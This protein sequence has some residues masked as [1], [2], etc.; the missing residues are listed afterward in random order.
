MDLL[1]T[2]NYL[3]S[4]HPR[5]VISLSGRRITLFLFTLH[6]PRHMHV[7]RGAIVMYPLLTLLLIKNVSIMKK[8]F[9]ILMVALAMTAFVACGDT[10]E[11]SDN[12]G[13]NGTEQ[14]TGNESVL[15]FTTWTYETGTQGAS[16]Y[17]YVSVAFSP[18]YDNSVHEDEVS[19]RKVYNE[20]GEPIQEYYV[21]AYSYTGTGS[22]GNGSMT[23]KDYNT[24]TSVGNVTFSISGSTMTLNFRGE[25]YSLNKE[26][27]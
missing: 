27:N 11:G 24:G 26:N 19:V 21:G 25:T 16:N 2:I 17:Q 18:F 13:G 20:D 22:N 15:K 23:V 5:K 9:S 10:N 7:H 14:P 4:T 6:P 12:N 8:L 3:I 1:H